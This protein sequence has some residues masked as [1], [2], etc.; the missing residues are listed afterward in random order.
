MR[1]LVTG[2]EGYIGSH[3]CVVALDAGHEVAVVLPRYGHEHRYGRWPRSPVP[4]GDCGVSPGGFHHLG[5][6]VAEC[7]ACGRQLLSCDCRY[8]EDGPD[9]EEDDDE[10]S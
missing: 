4:C 9:D 8:D 1:L 3:F 7:P 10:A 5:C 6:D 2:G